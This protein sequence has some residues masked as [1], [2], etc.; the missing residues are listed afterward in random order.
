MLFTIS[1]RRVIRL[2]ICLWLFA[3]YPLSIAAVSMLFDVHLPSI[4]PSPLQPISSRYPPHPL[5]FPPQ[6]PDLPLLD[7]SSIPLRQHKTCAGLD[8]SSLANSIA[9]RTERRG[10]QKAVTN[11]ISNK[12]DKKHSKEPEQLLWYHIRA[13]LENMQNSPLASVHQIKLERISSDA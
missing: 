2:I 11:C 7:S 3:A 13:S 4:K 6:S 8:C 5:S 10:G 1:A 9:G 12:S